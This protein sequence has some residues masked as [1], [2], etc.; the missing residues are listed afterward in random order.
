MRLKSPFLRDEAWLRS[1]YC[2]EGKSTSEIGAILDC[3]K[4]AVRL[5][6]IHF[7]IELRNNQQARNAKVKSTGI[8]SVKYPQLNDKDWLYQKYITEK[9]SLDD[10]VALVGAKTSN[11]VAQALRRFDLEVRSISDGL[12]RN[13]VDDGFKINQSVIDGCLLGDGFLRTYN[14]ESDKSYPAFY[15]KNIHY[16]HVLYVGNL[17]FSNEAASR[18]R[19]FINHLNGK[20]FP[21]CGIR[22]LSHKSLKPFYERWYPASNNYIKLVPR[23]IQIDEVVLLHWFLDDGTSS[24]RV[25]NGKI[26]TQVKLSFCSESFTK[27]DQEFLCEQMHAKFPSV[28]PRVYPYNHGGTGYRIRIIQSQVAEFLRIIGP[29]PVEELAYKWK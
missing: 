17:L 6:L 14:R 21:C 10:I 8:K 27:E 1:R 9:Q 2:E 22:S 29:P 18:V 20:E 5:A 11:S 26:T 4:D 15:K 24:Y 25:R 3:S 28:T 16:N 19:Q 12:T 23:D 13:R 7:D